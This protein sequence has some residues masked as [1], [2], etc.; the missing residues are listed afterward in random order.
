ML[1]DLLLPAVPDGLGEVRRVDV[2]LVVL[3][4]LE[5]DGLPGDL[6][7]YRFIYIVGK[8]SECFCFLLSPFVP[9]CPLL[10]PFGFFWIGSCGLAKD[11]LSC[12][13]LFAILTFSNVQKS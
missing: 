12:R 9:F 11:E 5:I 2:V 1:L 8:A 13:Y 10:S 7:G 4:R 6:H 3:P